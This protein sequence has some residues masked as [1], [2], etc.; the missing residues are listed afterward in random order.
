MKKYLSLLLLNL[1]VGVEAVDLPFRFL[2]FGIP[3]QTNV[4]P[5]EL[6]T[7]RTQEGTLHQVPKN[8]FILLKDLVDNL[9]N[10]A[11]PVPVPMTSKDFRLINSCIQYTFNL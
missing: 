6:I 1:V 11:I 9:G 7:V 3:R 8:R 10:N 5:V 4:V 2:S